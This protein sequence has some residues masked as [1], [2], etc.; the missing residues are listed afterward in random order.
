MRDL[1]GQPRLP[2]VLIDFQTHRKKICKIASMFSRELVNLHPTLLFSVFYPG[3]WSVEAISLHYILIKTSM[4]YWHVVN[5][6]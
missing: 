2:L 6:E 1:L 5:R 3:L 4:A